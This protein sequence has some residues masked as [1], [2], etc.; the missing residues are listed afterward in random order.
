MS[1]LDQ[2]VAS[3]VKERLGEAKIESIRVEED[4]DHAG[5]PILR[6]T[7][8]FDSSAGELDTDRLVGITR[9][10]RSRLDKKHT[11]AFPMFRFIS[12]ADAA[13]LKNAAA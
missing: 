12:K 3:V 7:V 11:D 10:M 1:A 5:E 2:L 6:I 8:V 13:K 4:V 9:H